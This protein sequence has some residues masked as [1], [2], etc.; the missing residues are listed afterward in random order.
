MISCAAVDEV[1]P[2]AVSGIAAYTA[3]GAGWEAIRQALSEDRRAAAPATAEWSGLTLARAPE[4][5]QFTAQ[6]PSVRPPLPSRTARL[7][8]LALRQALDDA[9]LDAAGQPVGLMVNRN[10]GAALGVSRAMAPMRDGGVRKLSPL[11]FAHSL[12]NSPIT[13][14]AQYADLRGPVLQTIGGGALVLALD[15]LRAG[16]V[17]A[18]VVGGFEE[19]EV[20]GVRAGALRGDWHVP[21]PASGE[22]AAVPG[23]G[24]VCLVFEPRARAE[25]RG[26]PI[27]AELVAARSSVEASLAELWTATL[28]DAGAGAAELGLVIGS[29]CGLP[30]VDAAERRA[31]AACAL[32]ALPL[33]TLKHHLGEAGGMS[34][35]ASLAYAADCVHR[36][37][38]HRA[39]RGARG[40]TEPLPSGLALVSASELQGQH[41]AA[42]MRAA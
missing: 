39:T 31:L 28:T 23:E 2:I 13:V 30:A 20:H 25:A 11:A 35:A 33:R 37:A 14:A 15:A 38:V 6:F 19:L 17:P 1:G 3:Y 40:G 5:D 18:I 27:Y 32:D 36:G 4:P 12:A 42:V 21:D 16:R 41:T 22:L 24:V 8:M 34:L 10:S 26:R 9:R 7:L 29:A